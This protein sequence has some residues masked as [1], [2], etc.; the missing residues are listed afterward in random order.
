[1]VAPANLCGRETNVAS[2]IP[3]TFDL[4][5][6]ASN[7]DHAE[8]VCWDPI[9]SCLWAGGEAGQI[10]RIELDGAVTTV[11]TIEYGSLLGMAL[12]GRGRLYVCD[13]GNHQV[14]RVNEDGRHEAFGGPI[15]Y[16]NYAAFTRDGRLF[17]SDSG[18]LETPT[19]KIFVIN[20]DGSMRQVPT[21]PI[22]YANGLCVEGDTLWVVES[23]VPGV[24]TMSVDGSE[25]ELV[26]SMERCTPDGLALDAE[27]GVLISCY[28][29]NQLWRWTRQSGLTQLF[30]DWTGEYIL[31]P[32]NVAFYGEQLDRLAL[33]SLCGS[34]INS[35]VLPQRGATPHYP[36][37]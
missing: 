24:S 36:L 29:P 9:R 2:P 20:P 11:G 37:T 1:M 21:R 17:V 32:T 15:D 18:E 14:W 35:V 4:R 27:G 5:V 31:S 12:D 33:A 28:Q 7:L 34:K 16:P 6:I 25:L 3:A 13:P 22:G 19:G 30:D 8:G 26:I 23:T 10:Y